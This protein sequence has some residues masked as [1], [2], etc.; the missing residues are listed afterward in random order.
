VPRDLAALRARLT[1]FGFGGVDLDA[2]LTRH[3]AEG[4]L[5]DDDDALLAYLRDHELIDDVAFAA[6]APYATVV[7]V[8]RVGGGRAADI[9][10]VDMPAPSR[11]EAPTVIDARLAGTP[12]PS[13]SGGSPDGGTA[14]GAPRYVVVGT[15]GKGG[16][17]TVRVARDVALLRKV[18]LKELGSVA[19]GQASSRARFVREVQV[20]AQ[21]DHPN[22][23]PVYGLEVAS[24]GQPA[25]AMKLVEGQTFAQLIADTRAFYDRDETPDEAHSLATR[26]DHF[27][28]ACDALA[29]AHDKGV[30]HRDLKPANLMLGAHREVYVMDWGLCRVRARPDA[31]SLPDAAL[32]TSN[33]GETQQGAIMGTPQ[34]MSPEQ[35]QGRQSELG[36]PSDQCALGLVLYELITLSAP[37]QA[38]SLLDTLRKA[39]QVDLPA[40]RHV[41]PREPIAPELSAIIARATRLDPAARYASVTDFADDIRRYLRGEAVLARPDTRWQRVLRQ[42]AR[43]RQ[44]VAMT[45][46]GLAALGL[47]V[48]AGLLWRHERALETR[49]LR[50]QRLHALVSDVGAEGDLLQRQLLEVEGEIEALAAVTAQVVAHGTAQPATKVQGPTPGPAPIPRGVVLEATPGAD[51]ARVAQISHALMEGEA[52]RET[53]FDRAR[54]AWHRGKEGD[55]PIAELRMIF[56]AGLEYRYPVRNGMSSADPRQ[57]EWYKN[58]ASAGTRW[59]EPVHD[60][61]GGRALVPLTAPIETLGGHGHGAMALLVSLDGVLED[62][63]EAHALDRAS[64]AYLLDAKGRVLTARVSTESGKSPPLLSPFPEPALAA[65]VAKGD[66][67]FLRTQAFGEPAVIVFDRIHPLDWTLVAVASEARLYER[68]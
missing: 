5:D 19:A 32:A 60:S 42:M 67:G 4:G 56:D 24:D 8:E 17:G 23:V 38:D 36:A 55:S 52:L 30:I 2:A 25:Y 20:T 1:P 59:G 49:E 62:L 21:L 50:E 63:A 35:A 53:L 11:R 29:Y 34:Y 65:A 51:T 27:L 31:A 54:H 16:M 13:V 33:T 37:Y 28:K 57:E 9:A 39:S 22:I 41:S 6:A 7:V 58:A 14:A 66:A 61:H 64:A 40:P 68:P 47:A 26:L 43:R 15:A 44:A 18:A 46:L 45:V 10:T 3:L 48:I 12:A